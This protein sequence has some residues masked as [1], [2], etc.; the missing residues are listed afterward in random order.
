[1]RLIVLGLVILLH[2]QAVIAAPLAS[3]VQAAGLRAVDEPQPATDFQ[4][5]DLDGQLLRLQDQ[6]GKRSIR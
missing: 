5:S 3:L 6:Y 2:G 1:M 4:L